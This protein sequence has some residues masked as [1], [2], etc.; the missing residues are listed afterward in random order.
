MPD[1]LSSHFACHILTSP[2][3]GSCINPTT[4]KE[5]S[6]VR[7][8]T[9]FLSIDGNKCYIPMFRGKNRL[10]HGIHLMLFE[11]HVMIILLRLPIFPQTDSH[12]FTLQGVNYCNYVLCAVSERKKLP[13]LHNKAVKKH[14]YKQ[15]TFK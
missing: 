12:Y 1:T 7:I 13:T 14:S 5:I 11:G 10:S 8:S 3:W 2:A 15:H 6:L 4:T 9:A